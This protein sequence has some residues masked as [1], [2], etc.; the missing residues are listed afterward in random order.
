M[1]GPPRSQLPFPPYRHRPGRT[2]HPERHPDGHRFF[3]QLPPG[4]LPADQ[5]PLAALPDARLFRYGEELFRARYWW[6]AH[7]VWEELW[8]AAPRGEGGE[9]P[10]REA[11]RAFIQLAAAALRQELGGLRGSRKLLDAALSG[12]ERA[13]GAGAA[14]A[15]AQRFEALRA[16]AGLA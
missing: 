9:T 14:G 3:E 8:R 11:L 16:H 1:T 7:A 6:E 2:P 15:L 13:G 5:V 12:M 10:E 4:L